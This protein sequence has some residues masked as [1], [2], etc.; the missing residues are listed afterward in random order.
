MNE[1]RRPTDEEFRVA[2]LLVQREFGSLTEHEV[3]I[4]SAYLCHID[5]LRMGKIPH[6]IGN[7]DA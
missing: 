7:N 5:A 3:R 4:M 6:S 1:M 2:V